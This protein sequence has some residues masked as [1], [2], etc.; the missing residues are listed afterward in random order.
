[1]CKQGIKA[2]LIFGITIGVLSGCATNNELESSLTKESTKSS[3]STEIA[4][5]S[6]LDESSVQIGNIISF[7]TYEQ[8][9]DASNGAEPIEWKV[10]AIEDNK[11]LLIS[12]YVLDWK[13]YNEVDEEVNWSTCS[14][15]TWLNSDFYTQ[16][17]NADE[18]GKI[19]EISITEEG[20][21]TM[22][23]VFLLNKT[24]L[25]RYFS[26]DDERISEPTEVVKNSAND[27]DNITFENK[28]G[29]T[30]WIC[31]GGTRDV[32]QYI[33]PGGRISEQSDSVDYYGGVRPAIWITIE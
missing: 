18:S 29:C 4:S 31:S 24:E 28:E 6:N 12:K 17:F 3:E 26:T 15:R 9:G 13:Q 16:A 25:K 20:I 8:D 5:N 10:L 32:A 1:M 27:T 23:N 14:L 7:G 11:A 2:L 33:L 19:E 22:D 30:Y 21:E